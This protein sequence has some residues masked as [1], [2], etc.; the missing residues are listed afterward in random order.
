MED[1]FDGEWRFE[2][3]SGDDTGLHIVSSLASAIDS[4]RRLLKYKRIDAVE[5][6][7][8]CSTPAAI[9]TKSELITT[10]IG[11]CDWFGVAVGS[12]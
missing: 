2:L 3:R 6:F 9:V 4:A 5:I 7:D 1:Y 11:I 10:E 8:S 12:Y